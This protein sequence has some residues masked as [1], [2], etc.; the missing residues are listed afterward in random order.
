MSGGSD[1][2]FIGWAPSA[3]MR[4]RRFLRRVAPLGLVALLAIA[5]L[6]AGWQRTPRRAWFD[7][8]ELRSYRGVLVA[9][10]VPMLVLAAPEPTSGARVLLLCAEWK[11][12]FDAALA[13][14]LHLREVELRGTLIHDADGQAMVEVAA[15][16]VADV[17]DGQP[18][19][20]RLLGATEDLGEQVLRG[21]IVDSKCYLGVM[22][23]GVLK[24]HRACAIHCIRG[25]IPPILLVRGT[26][27]SPAEHYLLVGA[28]GAAIH[29]QVLD[30]VA[31]PVEIRGRVERIGA[32]R[33]LRADPASY[34]LL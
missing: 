7:F 11:F 33:V 24:P 26:D 17:G 23:P 4:D 29:A 13:K 10:P 12:G 3:P 20:E 21:E 30:L 9:D 18:D 8:G 5:A 32:L 28:D 19:A 6:F 15:G 2:F 25:G 34:R 16:S 31:V 27:G 14:R 1:D 22:N